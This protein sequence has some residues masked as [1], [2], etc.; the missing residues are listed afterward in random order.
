MSSNSF[1]LLRQSFFAALGEGAALGINKPAASLRH[2]RFRDR[3]P[4]TALP[5]SAVFRRWRGTLVYTT[6]NLIGSLDE[7]KKVLNLSP[8]YDACAVTS[9]RSLCISGIDAATS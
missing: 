4:S 2:G 7:P 3:G 5:P 9:S 8:A 1:L 6:Y